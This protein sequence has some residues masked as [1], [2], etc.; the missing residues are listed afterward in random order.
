MSERVEFLDELVFKA[1][2][3]L[4]VYLEASRS[5]F[6]MQLFS[7]KFVF[8]FLAIFSALALAEVP[9]TTTASE[10]TLGDASSEAHSSLGATTPQPKL[11]NKLTTTKK[12]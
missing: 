3:S 5:S 1:G 9:D 12:P 4:S 10:T 6:K 7:V 8:L 2:N 11:G